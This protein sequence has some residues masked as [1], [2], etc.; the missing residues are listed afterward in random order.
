MPDAL[1]HYLDGIAP[2]RQRARD[3]I[4]EHE[5]EI[6]HR[7]GELERWRE[8]ERLADELE[9]AIAAAGAIPPETAQPAA[10]AVPDEP[11]PE[12]PMAAVSEPPVLVAAA[13]PPPALAV[14]GGPGVAC[15]PEPRAARKSYSTDSRDQVMRELAA[16]G[17]LTKRQLVE[18]TGI[19]LSSISAILGDLSEQAIVT[20]AGT[21][22]RPPRAPNGRGQQLWALTELMD[23]AVARIGRRG[24][25]SGG[26]PPASGGASKIRDAVLQCIREG[27]GLVDE[28][29]IAAQLQLDREQ[30]AL[31]TGELLEEGLIR[32]SPDGTYEEARDAA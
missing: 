27:A 14:T 22:P 26:G 21:L 28:P 24:Q 18:R 31:A 2:L 10:P 4:A 11:E 25:G 19:G 29:E 6:D 20:V 16:D 3:R 7:Q 8:I 15:E 5:A 9:A 30:V 13:A 17:P 12:A 1:A 32:L 23:A